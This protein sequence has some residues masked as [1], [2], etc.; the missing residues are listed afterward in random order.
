MASTTIYL[1]GFFA[2]DNSVEGLPAPAND[3]DESQREACWLRYLTER[4]DEADAM[5]LANAHLDGI[6]F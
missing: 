2:N 6:T 3:N 5:M 4:M 1:D